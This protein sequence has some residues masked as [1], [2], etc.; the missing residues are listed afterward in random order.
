M[1]S[2]SVT[3]IGQKRSVNQDYVFCCEQEIG[4]L[5]NLFIVAD[6]MGGHNAGDYASKCSVEA[7]TQYI[8]DCDETTIISMLD[9]AIQH[10]NKLIRKK[11]EEDSALEG[12]GTTFVAATVFD[13]RMI[14]ANIG[15]SRLYVIG[16]EITQITRD[17]SLVEMMV[18][19]GELNPEEA[20]FHPNK[21]I[22]TRAIGGIDDTALADFFEIDLHIGDIVLLCSDGLSNMLDDKDIFQIVKQYEPDL[23]AAATALVNKANEQG[24]KDNI[25]IILMNV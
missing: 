6:G 5:P 13:H 16:N 7:V 11:A 19:N 14:V 12:M 25:A 17:H 2:F 3:D 22:V 20:R 10:A 23:E 4:R 18:Q 21:N 9:H 15:D 24:G 8:R 1:K